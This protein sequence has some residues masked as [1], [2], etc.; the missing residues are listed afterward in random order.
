M[1]M[2]RKL[3]VLGF[4]VGA[5]S[6]M[7]LATPKDASADLMPINPVVVRTLATSIPITCMNPGSHQD[8]SKTPSLKNTAGGTIRKGQILSW[9]SSDGDHGTI[10]L[11]A[12][13]APN[14]SVQVLG[15]PGNGYTCTS[16]FTTSPDLTIRTAQWSTNTAIAVQLENT[17]SWVDAA[18]SVVHLEVMSCSGQVLAQSDSVAVPV[19]KG[20]IKPLSF[21]VPPTTGK[22]YLRVK[23]DATNAVLEKNEMNN[24]FDAINSCVY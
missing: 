8:V 19:A 21:T 16:S 18:P 7:G 11:D 9:K 1:S 6:V 12:D 13:L 3:M 17:D 15:Q 22:R 14:A 2:G 23:A 24:L 4:M 20:Q 10:K 5:V